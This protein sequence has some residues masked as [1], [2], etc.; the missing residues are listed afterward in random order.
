[1]NIKNLV[2]CC[3]LFTVI[4]SCKKD[5]NNFVP[6]DYEA[7][8][9]IDD[10]ILI[11]YMENRYFDEE[12]EKIKLID[13]GQESLYSKAEKEVVR[14]N[15]IDY[16]LYYIID[17]VGS[18]YQPSK[19]DKVLPTYTGELLGGYVFDSRNSVA[20]GNPWLSLDNV[21]PGWTYGMQLFHSGINVSEEN[22]KIAFAE[23][24]EGFLFIPSG[25]G[26]GNNVQGVIPANAPLIFTIQLQFAEAVD[27]D[28]DG[29][30]SRY[31]D[32]DGDGVLQNDDTDG[33]NL[34]DYFDIDDDGD[35]IKTI[36]ED[37]NEDGNPR[38]DDTDNDGIPNY[39]DSDS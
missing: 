12:E 26:Y 17:K 34:P 32:V 5:D 2:W 33:D 19:F 3:L 22:G 39:L 13:D 11:D 7:Q 38:N 10:V 1:M 23:Y 21:I 37:T 9:I 35:G 6:F 16:N 15:E 24:G 8:A 25:L 36:E 18:G 30:A 14:L 31:E 28:N 27:H 4:I 29:V 20:A